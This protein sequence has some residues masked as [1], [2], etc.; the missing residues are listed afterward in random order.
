MRPCFCPNL[1]AVMLSAVIFAQLLVLATAFC[2]SSQHSVWTFQHATSICASLKPIEGNIADQINDGALSAAPCSPQR[3][4]MFSSIA[5][6]TAGVCTSSSLLQV[7][8]LGPCGCRLT[9]GVSPANALAEITAPSFELIQSYDRPRNAG[10][11]KFFS[12]SMSVGMEEYEMETRPY[13]IAV[14]T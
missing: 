9:R 1:L 10:V 2:T 12:W 5:S 8:P 13:K 11:D 7:S 6:A 3:R 14:K 4:R